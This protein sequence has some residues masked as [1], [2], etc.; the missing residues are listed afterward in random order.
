MKLDKGPVVGEMKRQ[1]P[2]DSDR[3]GKIHKPGVKHIKVGNTKAYLL[4]SR[5]IDEID[6]RLKRRVTSKGRPDNPAQYGKVSR[7]DGAVIRPIGVY[8]VSPSV[9]Y[10]WYGRGKWRI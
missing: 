7:L 4:N 10:W 3:D 2:P 1:R 6:F 8:L 9:V 5:Q